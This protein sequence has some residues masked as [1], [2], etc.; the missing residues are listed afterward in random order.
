MTTPATPTAAIPRPTSQRR[1]RVLELTQSHGVIGAVLLLCIVA[2][3]AFPSFAT[4]ANL[5][6]IATAACFIGLITIG[7]SLV[8]IS[9]GIDLSVGSMVG[10]A[11]VVAALAAPYGWAAALLAPVLVGAVGGLL[12][13][14]LI[15]KAR[16]APFI[17]TLSALLAF[18]GIAVALA[19]SSIVID[20]SS[21]F[22]AIGNGS[23]L[24][25]SN[26]IWVLLAAFAIAGLVLNRTAFGSDLFALGGN[27][28]AARMMGSNTSRVKV[29]VYVISGSLAGLAGA[30]LASRLSSG[31]STLG[32]GYELTSIAAAVIGGVL[33]TGGVG[34][35]LGALFGVLLI[36]IIQ[37]IINQVGTLNAYYQDLVTGLFLV[38]AVV[39]QGVLS[40]RQRQ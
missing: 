9:G 15:G 30:L 19:S 1:N 16:M 11:T 5:S 3:I 34:T 6:A 25:I 20:A 23:F 29:A 13:G 35:M 24:G 22:S 17:V 21:G 10:L 31:V 37:N 12:N 33:L 14:L 18:K 8:L 26:L 32:T 7:Q 36:G 28:D 39:V 27:E 2:A 40:N 4:P 38:L